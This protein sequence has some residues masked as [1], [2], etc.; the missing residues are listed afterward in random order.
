M[1]ELVYADDLKSSA[2]R[3]VGSNPTPGTNEMG[4]DALGPF[5]GKKGNYAATRVSAIATAIREMI[6]KVVSM[7]VAQKVRGVS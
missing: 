7:R 5:A 3:H 6:A 4:Q 1:A 2:E